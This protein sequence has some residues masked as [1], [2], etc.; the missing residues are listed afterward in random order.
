MVIIIKGDSNK[1]DLEEIPEIKKFLSRIYTV[2]SKDIRDRLKKLKVSKEK[3][4]K[5][6]KELAF[7]PKKKQI[8]YLDEFK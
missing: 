4:R 2:L 1:K 7:L 6:R 5:I 8:E 3:M